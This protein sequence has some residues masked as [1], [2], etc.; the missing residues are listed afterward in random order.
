MKKLLVVLGAAF[1][2][3]G[4]TWVEPEECQAGRGCCSH[5]GGECGCVGGRDKCCDGSLSPTCTC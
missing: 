5:H 3:T 4:L 2:L 1:V